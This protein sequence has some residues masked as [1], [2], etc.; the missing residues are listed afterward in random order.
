MSMT[1]FDDLFIPDHA[2]TAAR[3][4]RCLRDAVPD[5]LEVVLHLEWW[6]ARD[7]RH[8]GASGEWAYLVCAAG[9]HFGSRHSNDEWAGWEHKPKY[10]VT[11]AELQSLLEA[12]PRREEVA[13]WAESLP[14]PNWKGLYRPYELWPNPE[15]WHP[16]YIESDRERSGYPERIHAWR[17]VQA[18]LT[19]VADRI[20]S[21]R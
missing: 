21:T 8:P 11:W 3:G 7:E 14:T 5:A 9:M 2:N 16:S 4:L 1:L 13:A 10:L 18:I 12:D 6:K 17:L 20:E 15:E 19:D